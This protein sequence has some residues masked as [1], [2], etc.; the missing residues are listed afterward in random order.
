LLAAVRAQNAE[1]RQDEEAISKM[2]HVGFWETRCRCG[3]KRAHHT[4]ECQFEDCQCNHFSE[5]QLD[6]ASVREEVDRFLREGVLLLRSALS[7]DDDIREEMWKAFTR[8]I[9]E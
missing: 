3:H 5:P 2:V 4:A 6:I 7:S 8:A 9:R 1:R